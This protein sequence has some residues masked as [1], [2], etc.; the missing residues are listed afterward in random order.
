MRGDL[1][2]RGTSEVRKAG[3]VADVRGVEREVRASVHGKKSLKI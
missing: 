3:V 2:P 1:V